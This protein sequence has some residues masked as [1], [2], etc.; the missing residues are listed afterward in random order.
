MTKH[1]IDAHE[2]RAI[3]ARPSVCLLLGLLALAA[4]TLVG[5][6]AARAAEGEEGTPSPVLTET[7]PKGE[8]TDLHPLVFGDPTGLTT[9]SVQSLAGPAFASGTGPKARIDLYGSE[10]ELETCE[11]EPIGTGTAEQLQLDGIPVTVK[12]EAV[13]YISAIQTDEG[14]PS[15][16]S[17]AIPYKHVAELPEEPEE[18]GEEPEEPPAGEEPPAEEPAPT[19]APAP[20]PVVND[21]IDAAAP[22][23]PR[24]RT[25]PGGWANFNL[26]R[27]TGKAPGAASVKIYADAACRGP[28][29][30]R[31]SA[32]AFA[33]GLP[34]PVAD[35]VV[36]AF[37]GVSVAGGKASA[38]SAPVYYVEDSTRPR[39]RITFGPAFKTKRRKVVF[40]FKDVKGSAP[41]THFRC[42]LDRR[43]WRRCKSPLRLKK[44]KPR[45]HVLRVKAID[46]AGNR[47]RRATK[48]RF[49][50]IPGNRGVR[51]RHRRH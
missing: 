24:L 9:A 23:A 45:R 10:S 47:Q 20:A 43:K 29:V 33:A 16:C 42:K 39:T 27:V 34:V 46:R 13:T 50:V 14:V 25:V 36:V 1:R 35:N 11:G 5:A 7:E 19:P 37:T 21:P 22:P 15:E 26:P 40:R 51:T 12:K 3:A 6:S 31:G 32:A 38:C 4:G 41:G 44:L 48:R 30:A 17:N 49:R 28:V 8:G 18:E 2:G